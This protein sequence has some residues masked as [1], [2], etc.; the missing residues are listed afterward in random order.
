MDPY[1]VSEREEMAF[2]DKFWRE[3]EKYP[4]GTRFKQNGGGTLVKMARDSKHGITEQHLLS[5]GTGVIFDATDVFCY[6][7]DL[8][9]WVIISC[10]GEP[11]QH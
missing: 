2:W 9:G 3:Y 5:L 1:T 11:Y 7:V 6:P 10:T 8:N 4:P